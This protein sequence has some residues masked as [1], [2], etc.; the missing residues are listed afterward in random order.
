MEKDGCDAVLMSTR[1]VYSFVSPLPLYFCHSRDIL[2]PSPS[3]NSTWIL[4]RGIGDETDHRLV[5]PTKLEK[6]FAAINL[7]GSIYR[8]RYFITPFHLP[9]FRPFSW[10]IPGIASSEYVIALFVLYG[11]ERERERRGERKEKKI[12]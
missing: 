3:R 10:S 4:P 5:R 8:S 11:D 12:R 2:V 1:N 6:R 7:R 9:P